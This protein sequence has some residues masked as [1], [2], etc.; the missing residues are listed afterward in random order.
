M[1]AGVKEGDRIIKV[2]A[3]SF[4]LAPCTLLPCPQG[5]WPLGWGQCHKRVPGMWRPAPRSP[6]LG[7]S[8]L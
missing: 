3:P 6:L 5:R 7:L 2:S 8:G 1:R 4:W